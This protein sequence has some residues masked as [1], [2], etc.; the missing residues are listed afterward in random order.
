MSSIDTHLTQLRDLLSFNDEKVT[1]LERVNKEL[2]VELSNIK[3][4]NAN[5]TKQ[6]QLREYECKN[7]K[8]ILSNFVQNRET[9]KD[10]LAKEKEAHA[11]THKEVTEVVKQYESTI[12]KL[13]SK[14]AKYES[15]IVDLGEERDEYAARCV[16]LDDKCVDLQA[17]LDNQEAQI[18][19]LTY[20]HKHDEADYEALEKSLDELNVKYEQSQADV[21]RL[22]QKIADIREASDEA[23][24]KVARIK[25]DTMNV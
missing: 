23:M 5:L 11:S 9:A 14:N 2:S 19:M 20:E 17:T 3:D 22:V 6:L 12:A 7:A 25:F 18:N 16:E 21:S 15:T 1:R 8:Q 24:V 4:A 10:D 13:K